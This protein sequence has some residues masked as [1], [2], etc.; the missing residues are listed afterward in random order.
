MAAAATIAPGLTFD[1]EKLPGIV[2]TVARQVRGIS[3]DDAE[4]AVGTAFVT[5][6]EKGDQLEPGRLEPLIVKYAVNKAL[7][8]IAK[9]ARR[10]TGS[11]DAYMEADEDHAPIELA[12]DEDDLDSAMRLSEARDNPVL[13]LRLEAV[14]KGAR[15]NVGPRGTANL[16]AIYPD[17]VVAEARRLREETD[18]SYAKIAAR[19]DLPCEETVRDWCRGRSRCVETLP[20]WT[21]EL[22]VAA[23]HH[24]HR[25]EGRR[26]TEKDMRSDPRLPSSGTIRRLYGS[27]G[28]ALEAAGYKAARPS[29][30]RL[31]AWT[32]RE[33]RGGLDAF[34]AEHG[35]WPRFDEFRACN[36][37]PSPM[38]VERLC[39]TTSIPKIREALYG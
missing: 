19:L 29:P 26:P 3:H 34:V 18:L 38:V 17:D 21:P 6:M 7:N 11:L 24:F 28:A 31:A 5:L 36:G 15:P 14:Q 10:K 32:R 9:N 4:E 12:V 33:L 35:R 20:G 13:A 39:G 2:D 30:G 16:L 37:L 8:I 27:W 22:T 25:E 1:P 23:I